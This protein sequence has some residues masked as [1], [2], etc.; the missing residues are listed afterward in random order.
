MAKRRKDR[1][2]I[3]K[4]REIFVGIPVIALYEALR[5]GKGLVN[6]VRTEP[7]QAQPGDEASPAVE[8]RGPVDPDFRRA[9]SVEDLVE[10][11][12]PNRFLAAEDSE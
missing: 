7:P 11:T 12:Y 1:G 5:F 10:R 8:R 6:R 3:S 9:R 4:A 2:E